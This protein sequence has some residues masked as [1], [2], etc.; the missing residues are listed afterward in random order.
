MVE[1]VN[2]FSVDTTVLIEAKYPGTLTREVPAHVCGDMETPLHETI[3]G[4]EVFINDSRVKDQLSFKVP[5]DLPAGIYTIMVKVPNIVPVPGYGDYLWSDRQYI[6][7]LPPLSSTFQIASEQLHAVK[8]TSPAS[9][10]SD[11][12]GLRA[13]V[14]PVNAGLV[15]GETLE[16]KFPIF[17]DV[18]SGDTR[19][20]S[21]VLFQGSGIEGLALTLIGFE[22]DSED[23]YEKQ[24][25]GLADAYVEI[26]KSS[27][28]TLAASIGAAGGAVALALGLAS[29]WA[30]AIATA[31]TLVI[32]LFVALWAPADLIIEDAA[33]FSL[34]SLVSL[35]SPNYP[36]LT[37]SEY[38]SA[39]GI[40]VTVAPVSK[41]VE[42]RERREYVSDEEDSEYHVTLRYSIL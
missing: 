28:N 21:R 31:I 14:I 38:E 30:T 23:A 7:V 33:A 4:E 32:N 22:V 34:L 26:L 25:Q 1:G 36:M 11:E 9:F 37:G 2:F 12:V 40:E 5:E 15:P 6:Q 13:I 3:D 29:A 24:I 19:D 16:H 8:E 18:D 27:W 39:G 17:G 42:Y 20:M 41:A 35:I 10:G